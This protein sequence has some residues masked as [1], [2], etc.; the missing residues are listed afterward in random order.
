M[1]FFNKPLRDITATL[2]VWRRISSQYREA[3]ILRRQGRKAAAAFLF[4]HSLPPL[5]QEWTRLSEYNGEECMNRLRN[6]FRDEFARI[7]RMS[8]DCPFLADNNGAPSVIAEP[9]A[10][11]P[12]MRLG[13]TLT[14][15]IA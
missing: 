7:E 15:S 4:K 2:E 11:I 1:R 5:I 8:V 6:L 12:A 9:Q 13:G 3:C 10:R 14:G